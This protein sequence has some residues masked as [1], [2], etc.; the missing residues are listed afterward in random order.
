MTTPAD[1]EPP[2]RRATIVE[3]ARLA[4][5]SHQT[6]SR[7]F[8]DNDS[9]KPAT[10]ERVADAVTRLSYRPDPVARSMRTRR[11]G[12][13]A[14][15]VPALSAGPARM[16]GGSSRAA[17][18]AGYSV[19]VLSIEGGVTARTRRVAELADSGQVD[20]VVSFAPVTA[21]LDHVSA[22]VPVIVAAELDDDMR[23]IGHLA[24]ATAVTEL[25]RGLTDL[26]HRRMMHV[27]GDLE[28]ASARARR[29]TFTEAVAAHG[30]EASVVEGD[31]TAEDGRSAVHARAEVGRPT[32]IVA[33]ND[34]IAAG[35]VRA[36]FERGWNVPRDLSVTGWDDLPLGRHLLPSLTTVVVDHERLGE[37]A[38]RRLIAV[39][40]GEDEPEPARATEVSH[41]VWRESTGPARFVM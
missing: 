4:G 22:P 18:A 33:A 15:V 3:V 6:V 9:L 35:V 41:V 20:G 30:G 38:M 10:R 16:L 26:G 8:R 1:A 39:L 28:F 37:I 40:R 11:T 14:I 17:H 19:D 27:T 25:V 24:D 13:L 32:A 7:F 34:V 29:H 36:A 5:V 2:Q 23:G 31:W 12:R 21:D